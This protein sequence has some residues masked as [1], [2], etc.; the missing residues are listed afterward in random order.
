MGREAKLKEL[1]W[2][3][4]GCKHK[5]P[6]RQLLWRNKTLVAAANSA[7]SSQLLQDARQSRTLR[8][9][10]GCKN[11]TESSSFIF[12]SFALATFQVPYPHLD[13][14]LGEHL[15]CTWTRTS[16]VCYH[17][18]WMRGSRMGGTELELPRISGERQTGSCQQLNLDHCMSSC[19]TESK[20]GEDTP[21]GHSVIVDLK[22][23]QTV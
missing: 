10:G 23:L 21:R 14:F 17:P 13:R 3:A 4:R 8:I 9:K 20:R 19:L 6:P 15:L 16:R 2:G 22:C 7:A 11:L 5:Q 1:W 12:Q 18:R